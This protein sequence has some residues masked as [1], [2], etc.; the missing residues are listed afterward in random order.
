MSDEF[1]DLTVMTFLGL[2]EA[3]IGRS[4][5]CAAFKGRYEYY[6]RDAVAFTSP[7]NWS[8]CE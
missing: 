6:T 4:V 5:Y 2:I 3:K 7:E 8:Y 1:M